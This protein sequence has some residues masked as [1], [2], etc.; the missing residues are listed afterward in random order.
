MPADRIT[1]QQVSSYVSFLSS[2]N[3]GY[4]VLNR[5]QELHDFALLLEPG[6]DW[7]FIRKIASRVRS[8]TRPARDKRTKVIE[9]HELI[10]LGLQL[11]ARAPQQRSDSKRAMRF[12]DGLMIA[13]LA[14][15]PLRLKNF[16]ALELGETLIEAGAHWYISVPGRETKNGQPIEMIWPEILTE[17]LIRYLS[18]WRPILINLRG[19]WNRDP[20]GRLW[21]SSH[22]SP[23]GRQAIYD[24]VVKTTMATCGRP[25]NPH[26]MR[27]CAATFIANHDPKH[28]RIAARVLGHSSFSTTERYYN[29]ANSVEAVRRYQRSILALSK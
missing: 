7:A 27:D 25:I 19:R 23:M 6:G 16:A 9:A 11:M 14:A 28:V 24:R 12:R 8:T 18:L 13:T 26:L 3:A 21:L 2:I 4:T 1:P 22:G 10:E 15:R 29:Q 5:L 20:G 17:S